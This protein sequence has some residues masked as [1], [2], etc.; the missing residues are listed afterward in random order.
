[1]SFVSFL[2][3]PDWICL[4]EHKR[5]ITFFLNLSGNLGFKLTPSLRFVWFFFFFPHCQHDLLCQKRQQGFALRARWPLAATVFV[6]AG[7]WSTRL[8][9]LATGGGI[10]TGDG[11]PD[12]RSGGFLLS[13]FNRKATR[14]LNMTS[15][16]NGAWF[17]CSDGATQRKSLLLTGRQR[18]V[19]LPVLCHHTSCSCPYNHQNTR[20]RNCAPLRRILFYMKG[21]LQFSWYI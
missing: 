5:I 21:F 15:H 20:S 18:R 6:T 2:F 16:T 8:F 1:M 14:F 11:Q 19:Y 10:K 4:S 3:P 9:T 12:T 7:N 17:T 13:R